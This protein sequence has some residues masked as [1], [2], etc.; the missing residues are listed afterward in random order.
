[1]IRNFKPALCLIAILAGASVL[2]STVFAQG[3]G[4]IGGAGGTPYTGAP[5]VG[6]FG[7]VYSSAALNPYLNPLVTQQNLS[8]SDK[9]M[10]LMAA[11]QAPGGIL[12]GRQLAPRAPVAAKS[13]DHNWTAMTPGGGASKYFNRI[14]PGET[15]GSKRYYQRSDRYYGRNGP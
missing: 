9:V 12:A 4:G 13:Q 7:S 3:Y 6:S 1:M 5:Y 8:N 11:Q 15:G 14:T 10:Y 2:P